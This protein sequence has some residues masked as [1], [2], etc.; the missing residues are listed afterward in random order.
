MN[1]DRPRKAPKPPP[2]GIYSLGLQTSSSLVFGQQLRRRQQRGAQQRH[3]QNVLQ[4]T[5]QH[6]QSGMQQQERRG[7]QV[8]LLSW[9]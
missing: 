5:G 9:L 3:M 2:R 1:G 7:N 8:G 6:R 4:G